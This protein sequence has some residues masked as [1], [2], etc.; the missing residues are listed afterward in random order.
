MADSI[1]Q[2]L[3][4]FSCKTDQ[5]LLRKVLDAVA[6]DLTQ[7]NTKHNALLVKMDADAGITDSNY[8]AL[9]SITNP[10]TLP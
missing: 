9:Y 1:K 6:S 10:Q 3:Q 7:F 8:S 4:E 5:I 2:V